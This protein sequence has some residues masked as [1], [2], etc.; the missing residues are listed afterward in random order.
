[1]KLEVKYLINYILNFTEDNMAIS[2]KRFNVVFIM[3]LIYILI[4]I[5][6]LILSFILNN[7]IFLMLDIL[8][9][10]FIF[11]IMIKEDA[12]LYFNEISSDFKDFFHGNMNNELIWELFYLILPFLMI[13]LNI[14]TLKFLKLI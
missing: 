3:I 1:M 4:Y 11:G 14:I 5:I 7:F 2:K 8:I 12:N 6:S 13:L 9:Y 10:C